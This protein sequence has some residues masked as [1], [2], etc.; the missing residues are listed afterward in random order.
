MPVPPKTC[1]VRVLTLNMCA[2]TNSIPFLLVTLSFLSV[3]RRLCVSDIVFQFLPSEGPA[4]GIEGAEQWAGIITELGADVVGLQEVADDNGEDLWD[5]SLVQ[6]LTELLGWYRS[7]IDREH[8]TC[9]ISRF[10]I[11]A[12]SRVVLPNERLIHVLSIHLPDSPYQIGQLTGLE[13]GDGAP[14]LVT[15]EEAEEGAMRTRGEVML[16]VVKNLSLPRD[17]IILGDFNEASHLDWTASAVKKGLYPLEVKWPTTD[18]LHQHGFVDAFRAVHPDC[19]RELGHSYPTPGWEDV[20][21]I[22][23]RIDF[24]FAPSNCVKQAGVFASECGWPSDH[25]AVWADIVF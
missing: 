5:F 16:G 20:H 7:E 24:I 9:V 14:Q 3:C 8:H 13:Y 15:A 12:E 10:P 19:T 11:D 21:G 23:C 18:V 2:G 6:A 4:R 17:T 22:A 1:A 25:A